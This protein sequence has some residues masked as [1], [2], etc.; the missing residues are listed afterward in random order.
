[1]NQ[2]I[3]TAAQTTGLDPAFSAIHSIELDNQPVGAGGFGEAYQV[4]SVNQRR[5]PPQIVKLLFDDGRGLAQHGLETIQEL[6]RRLAQKD[7]EVRQKTGKCLLERLPGL[8]AVPQFSFAGKLNDRVV[9]GY[10]ANDLTAAGMEEFGRILES[11]KKLTQYQELALES[12]VRI[13]EELVTTF[14]FLSTHLRYIHAD[15]KA[16]ALFIDTKR[17][18]CAIIDFDSGALARDANDQPT[19]FGTMQDWLAPEIVRQL[20]A[21]GNNT[22]RV[23]VDLLS[24]IWSVNIAIHYLLFGFHP[25]FFL[26]EISE[27]SMRAYLNAHRWPEV[28]CKCQYFRRDLSPVY[29]RYV[30]FLREKLPKELLQRFQATFNE[31]YG[32]PARR[33]TYG[34][35]KIVLANLANPSRG[36]QVAEEPPHIHQFAADPN[37]LTDARPVRLSWKVTG[38]A[39]IEIEG[40][41]DVTGRSSVEIPAPRAE[42]TVTLIAI[43]RSG[44]V[45]RSQVRLSVSKDSPRIELFEADRTYLSDN[46]PVRLRWRVSENAHE[47]HL[48]YVGQVPREGTTEVRPRS[49][50]IYTLCAVTYFGFK[51]E[52]QLSI[53]VSKEPPQI[54]YLRAE[55]TL[56]WEGQSLFL[57][58]KVVNCTRVEIQPA[59]GHVP[60]EGRVQIRPGLD[61]RFILT[62]ESAFGV[63]ATESVAVSVVRPTRLDS[64]ITSLDR[65][66]ELRTMIAKFNKA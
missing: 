17:H 30:R 28:S 2:I 27:R 31:G 59:I 49:E 20:H 58:W 19:T 53:Q 51:A 63:T 21:S 15:I 43:S 18:R 32:D 45:A 48:S 61:T 16:E 62:A 37:F 34:Q 13:A 8:Y 26:T 60:A 41:G 33:T 14:E 55:P 4:L 24:D 10:S 12:K 64:R 6:Q 40:F 47:V 1:M 25:Y 38:A 54:V 66:S 36:V 46:R 39:K 22:R 65:P 57:S 42:T 56:V 35:W 52:Q 9:L 29:D 7:I 23:H 50:R 44:K 11:E 3:V 5:V